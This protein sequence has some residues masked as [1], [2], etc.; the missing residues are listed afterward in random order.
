MTIAITCGE[1]AGIGPELCA[2]VATKALPAAVVA[3]G[4]RQLLARRAENLG[5]TLTLTDA[6]QG[7]P[8]THCPGILPVI[9]LPFPQPDCV[10]EPQTANA[11]TLLQGLDVAVDGCRSGRFDAMVT[12]P[13]QKSVINDAG[14]SFS[15][16]TEYIAERCGDATPVMLLASDRMRVALA[17]T[18]MPLRAVAD[19]ITQTLL[20]EVMDIL[21]H[22]LHTKF[23]LKSPH[24]VVCGLNPHAGEGG[25]LGHEDSDII[26][27]AIKAQRA[28]G[29]NIQGPFPADTLFNHAGKNADA[30]L[31]MYHDQGLPVIKYSGFGDIVNVTLGLPIVRTSVDHGSA[32]D[33]AGKGQADDSSL[34]AA[35]NM[36]STLRSGS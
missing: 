2:M 1:P 3:I 23:D 18:H 27:P 8:D 26:V 10:A 16:H 22:D 34:I 33:I 4:D 17:T 12:A 36:A 11:A 19:A 32:L 29:R 25:H 14:F 20:T 21:W 7:T 30:I 24:V 15:G 35:I 31:A 13:L 5:L 6:A 28:Q 9:N